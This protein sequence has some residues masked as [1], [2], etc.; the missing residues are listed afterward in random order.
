VSGGCRCG[1]H[2]ISPTCE[3]HGYPQP[4]LD[5]IRALIWVVWALIWVVGTLIGAL[6]VWALLEVTG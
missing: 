6:V 5:T 3:R 2:A 4:R 1:R